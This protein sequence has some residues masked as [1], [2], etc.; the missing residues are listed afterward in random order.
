MHFDK[1]LTVFLYFFRKK[2]KPIH[3]AFSIFLLTL[4][5]FVKY[6]LQ[7][8][9]DKIKHLGIV[10]NIDGSHVQVKIVQTSACSSCSAKGHCNA[11]ETKEK[12][13]DVYNAAGLTC[14]IGDKVMVCGTTSMGMQAVLLAFGIP[15]L[16]LLVTLFVA[17]HFTG[18]N[19]LLSGVVAM[20]M[21]IPYYIIIYICR[22][23]LKRT[24]AFTLEEIN[25]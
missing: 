9:T 15:F 4:P 21:L 25:Y 2:Y 24:F 12:I 11:S 19:E 20:A 7:K 23:R 17:M 18:G 22:K 6:S 14:Q 5:K 3:M 13:V 10:E 8:M 1:R 16:I